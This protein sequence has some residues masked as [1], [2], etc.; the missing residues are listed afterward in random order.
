MEYATVNG[1]SCAA[2]CLGK[3]Y[4]KG[5]IV[6]RDSTKAQEYL[7]QSAKAGNQF[8][9]YALGKLYLERSDKAEAHYWFSQAANQGNECAQF[10]LDHWDSLNPSSVMLSVSTLLHHMSRIFH[11][12]MP[13]P[14]VPGGIQIDR[15]R[16]VQLREKKIAMG[17]KANDH[18][19]Q[20]QN[21]TMT[22]G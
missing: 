19:E 22:M 17:H 13:V 3:E 18:E 15:K 12:Q 9:Q 14:T 5:E 21:R 7:T 10:F 1:S 2:Y 6:E 11:E 16:L 4:L 20:A 8:A